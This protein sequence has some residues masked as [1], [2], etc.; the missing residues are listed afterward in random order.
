MA[1]RHV[2]FALVLALAAYGLASSQVEIR[3]GFGLVP[4]VTPGSGTGVTLVNTGTIPGEP[5]IITI[6]STQFVTAGITHD[7]TI[8]T[9]PVKTR[10]T[11]IYADL[12]QTFACATV[13]TSS[14]LQLSVG[15]AAGGQQYLVLW[16]ADAA[17]T[18]RGV[19]DAELGTSINRAN[20]IQGAH[21]PSWSATQ[22]VSMR[23]TSV[24]G[25]LGN[26][27]VTNLS[28][29]SVTVYLFTERIP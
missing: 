3:R 17:T 18:Q 7:V 1:R 8:G 9:L 4:V 13:C 26:G 21:L 19:L 23:L 25:N 10:L 16:D 24:T 6:G 5:Y 22:A 14:T 2:I 12:T 27:T 20:A 29:G 28:Q 11:A 15:T